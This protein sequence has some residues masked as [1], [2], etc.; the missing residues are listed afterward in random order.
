MAQTIEI[1]GE[2]DTET[3]LKRTGALRY[4]INNAAFNR[5]R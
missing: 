2:P 3:I 5:P 4:A 1:G